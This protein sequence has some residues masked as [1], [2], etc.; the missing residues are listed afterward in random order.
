MY[1]S[2]A[3]LWSVIK[4]RADVSMKTDHFTLRQS[5]SCYKF[6]QQSLTF[7]SVNWHL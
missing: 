5:L 2:L 7:K 6:S 4:I 3:A 1:Y